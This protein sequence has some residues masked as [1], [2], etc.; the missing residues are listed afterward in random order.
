MTSPIR[1]MATMTVAIPAGYPAYWRPGLPLPR[2]GWKKLR[3]D[4]GLDSVSR[5]SE[6]SAENRA[7]QAVSGEEP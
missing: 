4:R 1:H 5:D 3:P 2:L 6:K 7:I